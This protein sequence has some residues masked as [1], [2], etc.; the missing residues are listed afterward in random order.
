MS[1]LKKLL[2]VFQDERFQ[3]PSRGEAKEWAQVFEVYLAEWEKWNGKIN[4]TS[5]TD[6][7]AI[8]EKHIF[9]SLHYARS[10]EGPQSQ[11]MDIGSGA[12]FPGIPLKVIFPDI[13]LTLVESQR[14]RASFL[15]N[16]VLKMGL[17]NVE[18]INSRAEELGISFHDRFDLILFRGVGEVSHCLELAGPFLKTGGRVGF[19]KDP[20]AKMSHEVRVKDYF[21][22]LTDEIPLLGSTGISSKLMLFC[23]CST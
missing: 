3:L 21:M 4:L 6:K 20:E 2:E 23:K 16:C 7:G 8:I 11:V 13:F 5:E 19:K 17:N 1:H 14:K 18:V 9:D 10:V 22:E 15:R 12:G